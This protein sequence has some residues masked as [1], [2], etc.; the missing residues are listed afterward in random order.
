MSSS[1]SEKLPAAAS[2]DKDPVRPEM[3]VLAGAPPKPGRPCLWREIPK[4]VPG[5]SVGRSSTSKE[6]R[7]E[8]A[9]LHPPDPRSRRPPG[10]PCPGLGPVRRRG[11]R[12]GSVQFFDAGG[13]KPGD[14]R[15][16]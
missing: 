8:Y 12:R 14:G 3:F 13:A 15:L 6:I 11:Q 9:V 1:G 4:T 16:V 7:D 2:Q 5:G 10:G